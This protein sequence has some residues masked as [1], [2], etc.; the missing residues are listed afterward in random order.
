[1]VDK[2]SY[3]MMEQYIN[4]HR[5]QQCKDTIIIFKGNNRINDGR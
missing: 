2:L 4:V 3:S 1:M 5:D